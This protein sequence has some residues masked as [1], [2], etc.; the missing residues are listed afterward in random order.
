MPPTEY[1]KGVVTMLNHIVLAGRLTADPESRE[2]QTQKQVASFRVACDRDYTQGEDKKTDFIS[3]VAF[4]GTADFVCKYFTKGSMSIVS[5]RLQ[6]REW[7]DRNGNKKSEA[8]VVAD[9]VYFGEKKAEK[10]AKE[11][12][13]PFEEEADNGDL[14]F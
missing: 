13:T 2:T 7:T 8:E 5:G 1:N 12:A 10:S 9:R 3:V 11:K 6:I 14:P 4:G